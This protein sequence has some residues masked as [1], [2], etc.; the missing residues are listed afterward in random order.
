MFSPFPTNLLSFCFP[1]PSI[2]FSFCHCTSA[3]ITPK[4]NPSYT[5]AAILS[6]PPMISAAYIRL[7]TSTF[8]P[9]SAPCPSPHLDVFLGEKPGSVGQD[10]VDL[11][12]LLQL[13]RGLVQAVQPLGIAPDLEEVVHVQVDQVGALVSSCRLREQKEG[14]VSTMR[15]SMAW[16]VN[17]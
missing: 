7:L 14:G 6:P 15:C 9:L 1:A 13:L 17:S 16:R 3:A 5:A 4:S 2:P 8:T 10:F 12:E 11:P